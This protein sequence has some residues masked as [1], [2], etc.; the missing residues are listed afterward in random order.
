[1]DKDWL[2]LLALLI[3]VAYLLGRSQGVRVGRHQETLKRADIAATAL[4][5][6]RAA[7]LPATA[8]QK[9]FN[10]LL[11]GT[12]PENVPRAPRVPPTLDSG[13]QG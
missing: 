1:M 9:I 3:L 12:A 2:I 7:S 6:M 10:Y 13:E 8:S 4:E 11:T 5:Y